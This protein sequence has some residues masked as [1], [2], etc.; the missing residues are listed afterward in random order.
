M[1]QHEY[2]Q[3]LRTIMGRLTRRDLMKTVVVAGGAVVWAGYGRSPVSA[4]QGGT[5]LSQWYHEY[6]EAGTQDAA[7]SYAQAYT[8]D[9]AGDPNVTVEMVWNPG[10]YAAK[11]NAAL[12]TPDGPDIYELG[13]ITTAAINANQAVSLNDLYTEEVRADFS[14][15]SIQVNEYQGNVYGVRMVTD[16]GGIYYRPS[17]LE[18]A[19][20]APPTTFDELIAAS[21]ALGTGRQKGLF[22]GNDGGISAW[23]TLLPAAAGSGIIDGTT[24]QFNNERS[25]LA[26]QKLVELQGTGSLL[27]GAPV[28]WFDPSSFTQGLVA[29]QWCGLWAMPQIQRELG[30]DFGVVP[31]PALDAEGRP[32]TFF[33]GWSQFVNG[34]RPNV[35]A[36]K[37]FVNWLW[38]NKTDLQ[39]D[40]NLAYGF[41]VPPRISVANAATQLQSGPPADMVQAMNDYGQILPPTWTGTMGTILGD[42]V[43]NAVQGGGDIAAALADAET[44]INAELQRSA[45]PTA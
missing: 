35:D 16:T 27:T 40:W 23:L 18:A 10:D 39:T 21:T 12:L 31:L 29:M 1:S 37:A 30:E 36:A 3:D 43:T 25:V 45:T 20:V 14:P 38:I 17:L 44:Q 2:P 42:A 8:S 32:A 24:L 9:P 4:R 13:G 19:G 26:Y 11:L 33:G 41:H 34:N 6:G 5:T 28:E 15:L 7:L 22:C